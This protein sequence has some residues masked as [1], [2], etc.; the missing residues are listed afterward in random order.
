MKAPPFTAENAAEM[1]R[2]GAAI[3]NQIRWGN[4]SA[5]PSAPTLYLPPTSD[6]SASVQRTKLQVAKL[7]AKLDAALDACDF[8][9]AASIATIKARLWP[10]AQPTAG[11]L[12]PGRG[13]RRADAPE[14]PTPVPMPQEPTPPANPPTA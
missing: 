7:D 5:Q 10:L 4:R 12:R 11:A 13:S 14:A 6:D 1:G 2:R 9:L 8:K 3:T